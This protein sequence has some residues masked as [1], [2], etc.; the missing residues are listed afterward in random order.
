[1]GE[2]AAAGTILEAI[3]AWSWYVVWAALL[4]TASLLVYVGLPGTVVV[5]GLALVH[6]LVTGFEPIGWPLLAV[7]LGLVLLG[8]L[9]DFLFSNF[10]AVRRGASLPGAVGAF[11]GGYAGALLINAVLPVIGAVIGS[12]LGAFVGGIAGE[13]WRQRR[14]EPSL[15]I[16]S[17]AFVGRVLAMVAKH[18]VGLIMVL[19]VLKACF[20]G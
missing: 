18:A 17:H 7:L 1:M 10:W 4:L 8:E 5:L 20:P 19:L 14:L 2:P 12:L 6:A 3:G 13:W 15:R 11:A 9:I 16:G